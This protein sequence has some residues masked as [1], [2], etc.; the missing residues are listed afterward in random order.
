MGDVDHRSLEAVVQ[1]GNLCAH[2]DTK[3]CVEVGERFVKEEY[4]GLADDCAAYCNTLSLSTGE[5]LGLS[6]KQFFDLEDLGCFT[7]T[8]IDLFL[9]ELADLQS[10]CH[11]IIHGHVGIQSIVLEYHGDVSVFRGNIVY[12]V[13]IDVELTTG[14]VF[15]TC[16]HAEGRG[17]TTTGRSDEDDK[18][19]VLDVNVDIVDGL[20]STIVHFANVLE[21]YCGHNASN[22]FYLPFTLP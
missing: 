12:E 2:L 19:S 16:Y 8:L 1:G 22:L 21:L 5:G 7:Y 15:Q 10:E 6:V 18:L 14:D 11:V 13:S 3:F 4:L 20:Y 9:G 17:L